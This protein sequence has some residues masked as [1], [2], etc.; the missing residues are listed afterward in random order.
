MTR[1][2]P[3]ERRSPRTLWGWWRGPT[4]LDRRFACLALLAAAFGSLP[5]VAGTWTGRCVAVL[6]GD[7]IVIQDWG[8]RRTEVRLQGIDAPERGQRY[9]GRSRANL[10]ALVYR[11]SV[12]A[13]GNKRD[14]YGRLVARVYADDIDVNLSQIDAGLAWVYREY[15]DE[16][17]VE[18]RRLFLDAEA[19][20][21]AQG[22]GVW[23]DR[24]PTAPWEWRHRQRRHQHRTGHVEVLPPQLDHR[25][26]PAQV[27]LWC[28]RRL[29]Y[30]TASSRHPSCAAGRGRM[31]ERWECS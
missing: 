1:N 22:L 3:A 25:R 11:K 24:K 17:P 29:R 10:S 7:T 27:G 23:R 18:D 26:P 14:S 31:H 5:C 21:R 2:G 12:E 20:A 8:R 30:A 13:E 19:K 6:D 4:S 15:L 28:R 9:G 16:L